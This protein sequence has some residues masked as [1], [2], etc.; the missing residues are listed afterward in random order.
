VDSGTILHSL[1]HF[2][3]L[4]QMLVLPA[5][6]QAFV[7]CSN[8]SQTATT[9]PAGAAEPN[10]CTLFF[11]VKAACHTTPAQPCCKVC[12]CQGML[13]VKAQQQRC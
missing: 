11:M 12:L 8:T 4:L 9:Y 3:M 7:F 5:A 10:C 2:A 6:A 13:F 1:K